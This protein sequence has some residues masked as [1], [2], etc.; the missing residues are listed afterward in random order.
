MSE[1][2]LACNLFFFSKSLYDEVLFPL[3][4][5]IA[6]TCLRCSQC[7]KKR[8]CWSVVVSHPC[9]HSKKEA[10]SNPRTDKV[11]TKR[12]S[13][14]PKTSFLS[15]HLKN[16]HLVSTGAHGTLRMDSK[17]PPRWRNQ[18]TRS[19]VRKC[20]SAVPVSLP[21]AAGAWRWDILLFCRERTWRGCYRHTICCK[22]P[23][24]LLHPFLRKASSNQHSHHPHTP[25]SESLL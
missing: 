4:V 19:A 22:S 1:T 2:E 11:A 20:P 17:Q 10:L 24:V 8:V 12:H 6:S 13:P 16:Q 21:C 15:P 7:P 9:N 23:G 18:S 25:V 5:F 14:A 3:Q